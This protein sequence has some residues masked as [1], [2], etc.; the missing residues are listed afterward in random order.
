MAVSAALAV[1][2]CAA[3]ARPPSR[4]VRRVI[5]GDTIVVSSGARVRLVQIDTP[6]LGSGECYSRRAAKDLRRLIAPGTPVELSADAR[7]DKVDRYGRL[8]RYVF[9]GRMNVNLALV[10]RG[11]ATVWFFHRAR[12]RYAGTLLWAAERAR[13]QRWGLWGACRVVW[14]PYGPATTSSR[15]AASRRGRR[16]AASYPGV[17]IPPPPPDLDCRNVPYRHFRVRRPDP[18]HFDD[19]H[20]GWGCER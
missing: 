20:D 10:A 12:G 14:D 2:A 8:L 4:V 6:E 13:R 11:D 1:A 19:D 15:A 3:G 9:R 17:C 18:H 16:C 5:D 7:L